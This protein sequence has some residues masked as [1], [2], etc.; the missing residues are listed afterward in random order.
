MLHI[1]TVVT[2]SQ[3]YYPY[4]VESCKKNGYNLE[5]L[6]Y[7]E[8]WGGFN[9]RSKLMV[10]YLKTIPENDIV[11]FVDG[12][13]VICCR[14][15]NDLESVF[16][17]MNRQTGCKMIVAEENHVRYWNKLSTY[18]FFGTYNERF[19]NAGTY[20]G[21]VSDLLEILSKIHTLD[22]RDEADD[23][24]LL[25]E[26]CKKTNNEVYCDSENKLFLAIVNPLD[27]IDRFVDIQSDILIYKGN[28]PFFIHA[29]FYGYL[30]NIIR[31]FGYDIISNDVQNQLYCDFFEKKIWMYIMLFLKKHMLVFIVLLVCIYFFIIRRT[32]IRECK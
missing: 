13:D 22:N 15:L 17:D 24:Q 18:L 25:I 28:R 7:G 32:L 29:P 27:E 31:K 11:C 19:I 2:E 8:K 3:Y 4:L 16:L 9:W 5:V 26:Y 12:Y 21:F 6:G 30:E 14:N 20:V 23:Q 1:V 10:D